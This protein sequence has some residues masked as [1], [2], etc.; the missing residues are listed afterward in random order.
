MTPSEFE[1][2]AVMIAHPGRVYSRTTLLEALQG[3]HYEGVE[4]TIDVHI[5]NLRSKIERD[6]R[7]P[8]C[9]ETVFGVGYRFSPDEDDD[10]P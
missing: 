8:E 6:P 4:R 9:I 10:S 7:N 3:M 1:I 2:L 5:R